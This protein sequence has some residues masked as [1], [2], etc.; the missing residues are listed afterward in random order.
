MEQVHCEITADG[1]AELIIDRPEHR[2]ALSKSMTDQ[3]TAHL[4][5]LTR[6]E[7]NRV[8]ILRSTGQHF[9][10]GADIKELA[11]MDTLQAIAVDFAGCCTALAEFPRPVIGLVQ[12]YAL[13][14][15]CE[16]VEMC[17]IVLASDTASFGHP[18]IL[19]GTMPGAGGTQ[20]LPRLIGFAKALDLLLTGR[21]MTADEAER[22]G[23]VSRVV[24]AQKLLEEGRNLANSVAALSTEVAASIK[25]AVRQTAEVPLTVGL[26]EE[27]WAFQKT[28]SSTDTAEGIRAFLE[29]RPA[30][31]N[32]RNVESA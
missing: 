28:L 32:Q 27:R 21:H 24:Q 8:V 15:G 29:K 10:A 5:M 16:L 13:G 25:K 11:S 31:F 4:A 9:A 12:G 6:D 23:L 26:R 30:K 20:R 7:S 22:C 19:L 1:V 3:M 14:A 17:D 18:E 2:N